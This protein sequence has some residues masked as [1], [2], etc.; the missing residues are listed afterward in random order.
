M[1]G[2]SVMLLYTLTVMFL[3]SL[4]FL[5]QRTRSNFTAT[6]TTGK[7]NFRVS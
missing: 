1:L 2:V 4:M 7:Q 6:K 3:P 5:R